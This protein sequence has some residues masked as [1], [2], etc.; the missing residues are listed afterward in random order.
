MASA[1][2]TSSGAGEGSGARGKAPVQED[3]SLEELVGRMKLS[4]ADPKSSP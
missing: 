4:A 3:E 1:N 2:E